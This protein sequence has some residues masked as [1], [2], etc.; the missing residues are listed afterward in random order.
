MFAVKRIGGCV[1]LCA[2]LLGALFLVACGEGS[3]E[4]GNVRFINTVPELSFVDISAGSASNTKR[5]VYGVLTDYEEYDTGNLEIRAYVPSSP[6]PIAQKILSVSDGMDYTVVILGDQTVRNSNYVITIDINR[7]KN[8]SPES[9]TFSMRMIN[10]S[11][12]VAA[13]TMIVTKAG[14]ES[15]EIT[16]FIHA[17][18]FGSS[19]G[20]TVGL[21]V[22]SIITVQNTKNPPQTLVETS[23][24]FEEGQIISAFLLGAPARG[25]P[26]RLLLSNDR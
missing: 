13:A 6:L 12:T 18:S 19:S 8:D 4:S 10:A 16:P 21:P 7:D 5:L 14:V 9:G 22:P 11:P 3:N 25:V 20:Y 17:V 23:A 24:N 1:S 15:G 2:A 26:Y